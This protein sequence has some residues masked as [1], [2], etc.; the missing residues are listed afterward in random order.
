MKEQGKAQ[1][2]EKEQW[3]RKL[4]ETAVSRA[5]DFVKSLIRI[6]EENPYEM[7]LEKA[8]PESTDWMEEYGLPVTDTDRQMMKF[9][10][11]LEKEKLQAMGN[12]VANAFLHGF[13]SQSRDR[14]DRKRVRFFYQIGQEALA[15]EVVKALKEKGLTPVITEPHI[16]YAS[17]GQKDLLLEH[18]DVMDEELF[19]AEW[20]AYKAAM[21][22]YEKEL[23]DTCGMIGIDQFGMEPVV[24]TGNE[25]A[26]LSEENKEWLTKLSQKKR[27]FEAQWIRPSEI[28]FCKVAFPNMLVGERFEQ[29]F[30]DFFQMNAEV[31]E[32]FELLQQVLIDGLDTCETVEIKGCNGNE[33][34]IK[35]SLW[36]VKDPEKETKFLNCGGDLNIPYGEVFTTP[37]LTGTTGL[38]HVEEIC[39]KGIFY[40]D[41]RLTFK[42]GWVV[43][44]TCK[45]GKEYVMNRL[46]YPYQQ[47][48]MGE[49]AIGSNTKAYS[50]AHKYQLGG[51]LPILIYEKMGPH[52]AIGD[53]CFAR[54]EDAPIYN[55]YDHKEMV[56]RENEVTKDREKKE[57][58]YFENHVDITLPYHQVEYL[59]GIKKDG[60]KVAFIE[61][62]RFVLPGTDGL[63]TGFGGGEK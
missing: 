47:V 38:Y 44:A 6:G 50:I 16:L 41:L 28:S 11:G 27:D 39:L 10:F 57:D 42:D 53:P 20:E 37:R 52:I 48:T 59:R 58:V 4:L 19:H 2:A 36:P 18:G 26:F 55:M 35:I 61:K 30:D 12:T 45:E 3:K 7:I 13:I 23:K 33:T 24:D 34:D 17:Q 14:K 8:T 21:Y 62:G 46:L 25:N 5:Q 63:N 56:C 31:S 51:R 9:W 43:D 32:P 60:S 49:F 15:K 40:H 29:I 1:V 22:L 54:S